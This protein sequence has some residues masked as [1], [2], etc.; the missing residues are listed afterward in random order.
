MKYE[1]IFNL[2]FVRLGGRESNRYLVFWIKV[3]SV[4]LNLGISWFLEVIRI[5]ELFIIIF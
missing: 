5:K 4:F 2:L 3:E 1:L